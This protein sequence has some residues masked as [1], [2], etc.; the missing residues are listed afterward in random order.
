MKR[1]FECHQC[2]HLEIIDCSHFT[3]LQNCFVCQESNGVV[4]I[5]CCKNA[6]CKECCNYFRP[7]SDKEEQDR[8]V[9][10]Q[11]KLIFGNK[12]GKVHSVLRAEQ[13]HYYIIK[14]DYKYGP[15]SYLFIDDT[16]NY[17][18]DVLARNIIFVEGY[19]CID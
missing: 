11:G 12:V 8:W 17:D 14:R 1:L 16:Q 3:R 5:N 15:I 19:Q 4:A 9:K 2:N 18:D 10:N 6:I 13:G 7:I